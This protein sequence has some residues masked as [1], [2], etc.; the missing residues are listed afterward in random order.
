MSFGH[1]SQVRTQVLVLQT[2][3][4]L[5]R[6]ASPFGQ[7]LKNYIELLRTA[8]VII[9]DKVDKN[10]AKLKHRLLD[11]LSVQ[12]GQKMQLFELNISTCIT[13]FNI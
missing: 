3:V 8:Y 4:D 13:G 12:I 2:C 6:L 1:P 10:A 11:T 5:R 7:R 9:F